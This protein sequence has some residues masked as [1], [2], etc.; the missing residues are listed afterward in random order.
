MR[1]RAKA[2]ATMALPLYDSERILK[3]CKHFQTASI[4][5]FQLADGPIKAHLAKSSKQ[6]ASVNSIKGFP[7]VGPMHFALSAE[8]DAKELLAGEPH[9]SSPMACAEKVDQP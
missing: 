7:L 4:R 9:G 3:E 5:G 8:A 1:D 6:K 2:L